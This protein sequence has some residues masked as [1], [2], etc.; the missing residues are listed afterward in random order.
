MATTITVPDSLEVQLQQHAHAQHRSVEAVA[1]D[2][3]RE[4]LD[5]TP[6][7]PSVDD[8][9]A[10][11]QATAPHPRTIRPAHGSLADLLRRT[12]DPGDFDLDQWSQDWAAVEL[13]MRA[14]TRADDRTEGRG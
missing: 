5:T 3:L 1:L 2:L 10:T 14:M 11:I 8:V 9:V 4:A 7:V 13:E 6:P 12:P